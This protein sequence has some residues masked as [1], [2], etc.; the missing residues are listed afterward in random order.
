M[1][2]GAVCC[3][4]RPCSWRRRYLSLALTWMRRW[5]SMRCWLASDRRV[6]TAVWAAGGCG[7]PERGA[8]G[9]RA[10]SSGRGGVEAA[11][12]T[13]QWRRLRPSRLPVHLREK[14]HCPQ[15]PPYCTRKRISAAACARRSQQ[16]EQQLRHCRRCLAALA[17]SLPPSLSPADGRRL[18]L[19]P[20]TTATHERDRER[21]REI[22]RTSVT[23]TLSCVFVRLV[24]ALP[25][26]EQRIARV[27]GRARRGHLGGLRVRTRAPRGC[28]ARG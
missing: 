14:A 8:C 3:R 5:W 2:H 18:R 11:W 17:A 23:A 25:S 28:G 6:T 15:A 22:E 24:T 1:F 21:S 4:R 19:A 20:T 12:R 10:A 27:N 9:A 16:Q 13:R 26:R 7:R